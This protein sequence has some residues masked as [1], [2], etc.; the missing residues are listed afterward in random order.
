MNELRLV[1]IWAWVVLALVLFGGVTYVRL[2]HAQ[3]SLAAVTDE[4]DT[5]SARAASIKQTL[6]LQRQ[7]TDDSNKAADHATEQTQRVT[8]AVAVADGRARS[9][10]HQITGLLAQ[11]KRCDVSLASTGKT[12][13]DLAD[14]LA[15]LRREADEEAGSLAAALDRSRIAGQLCESLYSAAMKAR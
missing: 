2:E 13:D 12:R 1:P 11:R 3:S 6:T 9:L 10:Q 8:A 14:L 5:A 7:L 15:D 4:R